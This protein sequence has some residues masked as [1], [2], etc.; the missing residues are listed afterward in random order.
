MWVVSDPRQV[1]RVLADPATF[2]PDNALTAHTP[3]TPRSLRILL[4]AGVSLPPTLA[5]NPDPATHRPLRRSLARYFGPTR[6]AQAEPLARGLTRHRLRALEPALRAGEPVDLLTAL[7]D[8]PLLVLLELLGVAASDEA[9]DA[10]PRWS[11]DSLELF[12]GDPD[13][14]RQQSLARSAAAYYSWLRQQVEAA[15]AAPGRGVF[16]RLVS[17]GLS[18]E[19]ACSTAYFLLIA[20]HET[21]RQLIAVT[22]ERLLRDSDEWQRTGAAPARSQRA[23]EEALRESSP[24]HTWRR[25][26][27]VPASIGDAK[28]TTGS[29]VLLRLTGAGGRPDLAFGFGIHRCLGAELARM[30]A[31]VA[32]E[33]AAGALPDV[34]LAEAEVPRL[35]LLSFQAPERILVRR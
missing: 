30:E 28:L 31:R 19:Q 6:V 4:D 15:R 1:R 32:V 22:F 3:L 8:V 23:V 35:S 17:L 14:D 18:D 13:D 24:V 2:G 5:S 27:T 16:G 20:G 12:W 7:A 25:T 33:E 26:T 29:A 34:V 9:I 21:T 11:R 10:L